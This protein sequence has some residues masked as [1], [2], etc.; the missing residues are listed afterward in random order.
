MPNNKGDHAQFKRSRR[1]FLRSAGVAGAAV[2][3]SIA[4]GGAPNAFANYQENQRSD[5]DVIVVG[6]GFAGVT[7]A[8]NASQAGLRVLHLEGS[9]RVGGRTFTSRFANHDLDLGGTWFGWG[10]PH[11]WA[12]KMR[13]DMPIKESSA[14]SST[15]YVWYDDKGQRKVGSPDEYWGMM[16]PAN[17]TFYAP[18]REALPRP[19]NPLFVPDTQGL[20]HKTTL[21]A[22]NELSLSDEQKSL[23]RAFAAIN[24][25]S[26][27]DQSSYLDQLRWI[28]LSGFSQSFMWDNIARFRFEGGTKALLNAMQ[29][30]SSAEFKLG[31]PVTHV[32][33]ENDQV[34]VTTARDET[35]VGKKLILAVPLNVIHS[36]QFSPAISNTKL[37][38]S[39]QGHTGS[40]TKIYARLKGKRPLTFGHGDQNMPLCFLWTEYDDTDSQVVVGFGASPSLLDTT[41]KD[42]IQAAVRQYLPD[43]EVLEFASYDWNADPFARGTWCMYRPGWL[44]ETFEDLQ[45]PEGHVHFASAD[46]ASG[47]RGFIDG[48]IESGASAAA[49]VSEALSAE[50]REA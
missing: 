28:A 43:A 7:A 31:Q 25:H 11:I 22:I 39:E 2:G 30:D 23:L 8:R 18:A 16:A 46:I 35:F 49:R 27:A 38:I 12:E 33:Q 21:E 6:A 26:F 42:A 1:D 19:Y 45:A 10:Q 36:V 29:E 24:G 17:D 44:T 50:R 15:Q 34:Y 9:G 40:G 48:A 20:D 14:Y 3:G 4:L 37:D 32:R 41:S 5:Y 13:Y 47:W